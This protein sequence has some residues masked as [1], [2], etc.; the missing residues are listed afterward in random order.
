MGNYNWQIIWHLSVKYIM[1]TMFVLGRYK[2]KIT[3]IQ[4][5][6]LRDSSAK[7]IK[8]LWQ[9]GKR[10]RRHFHLGILNVIFLTT[11][12]KKWLLLGFQG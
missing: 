8:I 3:Q 2:H 1:F 5:G 4:N 10:V 6:I 12:T 9:K 11:T 7:E